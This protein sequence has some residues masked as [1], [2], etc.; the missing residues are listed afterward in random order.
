MFSYIRLRILF[1]LWRREYLEGPKKLDVTL[2]K[3]K[4]KNPFKPVIPERTLSQ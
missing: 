3:G 2:A 1:W 4:G